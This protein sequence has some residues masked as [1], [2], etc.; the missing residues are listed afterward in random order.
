[1]AILTMSP[2][3]RRYISKEMH[4]TQANGILQR[5]LTMVYDTQNYWVFGVGL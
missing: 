5:V 2:F 1:M 3:R 4:E